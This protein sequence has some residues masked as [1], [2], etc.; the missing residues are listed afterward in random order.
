M[1]V[2]A[3]AGR[4]E[5]MVM[6]SKRNWLAAL[7]AVGVLGTVVA[8]SDSGPMVAKRMANGPRP[9][10]AATA[11]AKITSSQLKAMLS[12]KDFFLVNVHVPYEGEIEKTDAFI[13][14]DKIP[15]NLGKLPK[16]RDA[17]IVV[18]CRTGRMSAL[19][20]RELRGLGY[21]RVFDL[22]GGMKDWAR[23]GYRIV[24]R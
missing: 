16:D 12:R 8:L 24:N 15:E 21:T 20:Q 22:S 6:R 4:G 2:A 18:Y 7:L 19:A 9:E 13:P 11:T 14:Y 3:T 1:V 5:L 10:P 23:R 17:E